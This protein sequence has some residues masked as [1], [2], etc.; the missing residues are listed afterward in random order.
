[1]NASFEQPPSSPSELAAGAVALGV[2]AL[3]TIFGVSTSPPGAVSSSVASA[4]PPRT[5]VRE[6]DNVSAALAGPSQASQASQP[7][8]DGTASIASGTTLEIPTVTP[9]PAVSET[10]KRAR[11]AGSPSIESSSPAPTSGSGN[12]SL[13]AS[14]AQAFDILRVYDAPPAQHHSRSAE[15]P[16]APRVEAFIGIWARESAECR[17]RATEDLRIRIDARSAESGGVRCAFRSVRQ[18]DADRW[19]VRASCN[20]ALDSWSA[21]ISLRMIGPSLRWSSE[22]GTETYVRCPSPAGPVRQAGA[23]R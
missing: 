6:P 9:P 7:S 22:R 13:S 1:M 14:R 8:R 2:V 17:N 11:T 5:V 23:A 15:T 12:D 21:N 16:A 18:E 4:A 3:I 19:R 20:A 10:Q